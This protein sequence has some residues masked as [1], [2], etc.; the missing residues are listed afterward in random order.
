MLPVL[1]EPRREKKVSL[2]PDKQELQ[3][4][5]V[6]DENVSRS[7][8]PLFSRDHLVPN[9]SLN[10]STVLKSCCGKDSVDFSEIVR[11]VRVDVALLLCLASITAKS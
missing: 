2:G 5:V 11:D 6:G 3:H 8:L 9:D 1:P 7:T 10:L 4:A